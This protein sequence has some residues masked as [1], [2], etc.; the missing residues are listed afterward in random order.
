M[1]ISNITK[2]LT[3]NDFKIIN[4]EVYIKNINKAGIILIHA[5]WCGHCTRFIPTFQSINQKL[6]TR[7][8]NFPCLAIEHSNI[9]EDLNKALKING[10]PTIKFFN[11]QGKII[12]SY[13]GNREQNSILNTICKVYKYCHE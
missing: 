10:F 8:I 9:T 3:A 5:T 12:G 6:N 2:N 13:N 1:S 4:N 7:Q 11:N